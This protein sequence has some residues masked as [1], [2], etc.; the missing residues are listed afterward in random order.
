MTCILDNARKRYTSAELSPGDR[1]ESW[2]DIAAYLRREVR[3]VQLWEKNEGLPVHRHTHTK[4]GTVYAYK[5]ELDAWWN[6]RRAALQEIPPPPKSPRRLFV[7]LISASGLLVVCAAIWIGVARQPPPSGGEPKIVPLTSDPGSEIGASFSPDGNQVAFAWKREG[8][9]DFDIYVKVVGSSDLLQLTDT[10]EW[11]VSPAWSPT[12][13]EIAF[14]RTGPQGECGIYVVSPLGGAERRVTELTGS[15]R[16]TPGCENYCGCWTI[17]PKLPSAQF[18]WSPDGKWLAHSG[19]SL[20]EMATGTQR[21]LSFPGERQFDSFPAFS[22]D[23][24]SLAFVRITG[25]A[26][27]DIYVVAARG[28]EPRRIATPGH[29]IFGLSWTADGRDIVYSAGQWELSDASLWRVS[30]SGGPPRRVVEARE[31]AWLPSVAPRGD[32][33]AFTRRVSDLNIWRV[34][35]GEGSAQAA[36]SRLIAS[37][38]VDSA[39]VFSPDG[40]RITF[41]SE[42]SGTQQVWICDR[43]GSNSRQLT[44]FPAPGAGLSTWSPDG[45]QIAFNSQVRKNHDIYVV[46]IDGGAPRQL[47]VETTNEAAPSWSRDGEWVYFASTRTG[48]HEIYKIPSRGGTSVQLTKG[49]GNRPVESPD[50]QYVI[51]EGGPAAPREFGVWRVPVNGGAET[52]LLDSPGSRWALVKDGLYFYQQEQNGDMAGRWFLTFH[53]FA[54][55]KRYQVAPIGIPLLGHRPAVSPDGRTI[56]HPQLD[57]NDGDV[58]LIEGFR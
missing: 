14:H 18:S 27:H 43:D 29:L 50:G 25:S 56:L 35:R 11:D 36:S 44:F 45:R 55:S 24:E 31:R 9:Q 19:I 58:M 22:P 41:T 49:G 34:K 38:W 15:G 33:L 6:S 2:K 39:P 5:T 28:G 47:T 13:R 1:L 37:T 4:R 51:Y 40:Q 30:V 21:R 23:G 8:R 12:G 26:V 42:R 48:R 46:G 57:M 54:T 32:R 3:T 16:S 53:E 7:T 20:I 10:P 52:L 17:N